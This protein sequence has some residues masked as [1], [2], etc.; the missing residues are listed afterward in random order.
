MTPSKNLAPPSQ[1]EP[2]DGQ[3]LSDRH[4]ST[5]GLPTFPPPREVVDS[6]IAGSGHSTHPGIHP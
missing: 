6:L 2:A 4:K 3:E 1:M 5:D